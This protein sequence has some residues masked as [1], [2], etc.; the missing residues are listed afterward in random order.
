MVWIKVGCVQPTAVRSGCT[1]LFGGAPDCTVVHW[2]VFGAP[3][4][5]PVNRPLSRLDGGVRL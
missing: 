2:T 3:G 5:V 4:P 1:G